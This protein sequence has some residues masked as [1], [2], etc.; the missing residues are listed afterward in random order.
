VGGNS[1][2]A[3]R[4]TVRIG[5]GWQG[6]RTSVDETRQCLRT[7]EALLRDEG[8]GIN[9]LAISSRLNVAADAGT[10]LTFDWDIAGDPDQAAERAHRYRQLGAQDF[11]LMPQPRDSVSGMV[12]TLEWFA[13]QVRPRLEAM[14]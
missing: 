3:L 1:P 7:L 13:S 4:R 10:E 14:A 6:L 2:A 12:E 5:D 11:L 8:R 9:E